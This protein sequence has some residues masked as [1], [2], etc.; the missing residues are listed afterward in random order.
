MA[1]HKPKK[2]KLKSLPKRPKASAPLSVWE[3][4]EDKC[5]EVQKENRERMNAYKKALKK[6][7]ADKKKK[8]DLMKKTQSLGKI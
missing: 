8:E 6:Y 7:E 2:P 5:K 1:N 3:R 4:Y